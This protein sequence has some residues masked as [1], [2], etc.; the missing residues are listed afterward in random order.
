MATVSTSKLLS[1]TTYATA[2]TITINN[3]AV[4]TV[5]ATNATRPGNITCLTSGKLSVVNSSP[6][7]PLIF[8]IHDMTHDFRFEGNGI[9]EVRGA[10]MLLDYGT[11]TQQSWNFSTLYGGVIPEIT[12]CEIEE[13]PGSGLY[14]PWSIIR[15]DTTLYD[16]SVLLNRNFGGATPAAFCGNGYDVSKVLFWTDST[17]ILRTGD[18]TNGHTIPS[19]CAIR[20]PNIYI[21]NRLLATETYIWS[22]LTVGTPTGGTFNITIDGKGTSGNI[23]HNATAATIDTALE[24]IAGMGAGTITSSGGPLPTAVVI[25]YAG[26]MANNR[27]AMRVSTSALTGGTNSFAYAIENAT[28]NMT[29]IDLNP[30]GTLD[31]EWCSFSSKIRFVVDVFKAVRLISCGFCNDFQLNNTNGSVEIDGLCVDKNPIAAQG[32]TQ[33]ASVLGPVSIKRFTHSAKLPTATLNLNVLPGFTSADRVYHNAYGARTATSNR[34]LQILTLPA[35]SEITRISSFGAPFTF[36]NLVNSIIAGVKYTDGPGTTQISTNAM[37]AIN[38]SNCAS[39]TFANLTDGGVMAARNYTV[40][41]DAASLNVNFYNV[42][43]NY[44]NNTLGFISQQAGGVNAFNV[45]IE[46]VRTGPMLDLPTTYLGNKLVVKKMLNS[47]ATAQSTSGLD[48]GQDNIYD[49]VASSVVGLTES[50][51]GINNYVGG[52]FIDPG[53]LSGVGT[54]HLTIGPIAA[55]DSLELTGAAYTNQ[56]G[57]L[58]LPYVGDSAVITFPFPIHAITSFQDVLP[59]LWMDMPDVKCNIYILIAPGSPTGGTYTLS[60][61]DTDDVL[62][63]TTSAL[64]YN[65][66]T[67]AIDTALEA[68]SGIGS[69]NITVSGTN[70]AGGFTITFGGSIAASRFSIRVDGT[71]LTG[72]TEPGKCYARGQAR[73]VADQKIGPTG[74]LAEFS[75]RVPGYVW[76]AYQPLVKENLIAVFNDYYNNLT[77]GYNSFTTGFEFRVRFTAGIEDPYAFITQISIP[78]TLD[79]TSWI[80][81][82]ATINIR[83]TNPT[84]ITT[85]YTLAGT[86]V[87]TFTGSGVKDFNVGSYF[88]ELCYFT[89][90]NASSVFLASTYSTPFKLKFGSNGNADLFVGPQV[91]LAESSTVSS[92]KTSLDTNIPLLAKET[93]SLTIS[94]KVDQAK[95]AAALAAALSA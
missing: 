12:Y 74:L 21:T 48:A 40:A 52:N 63:G 58:F 10:P 18:G 51:T 15:E 25:S 85:L 32:A 14:M 92:I 55:G 53:T 13:S 57:S 42:N 67:T 41:T 11:D 76:P 4:L 6:D 27:N 33:I 17:K 84:D 39:V 54:G 9:F 88:N 2:E 83:G 66:S 61:Y 19:G 94:S 65:A 72:G 62:L 44:R 22:V 71:N 95:Q 43:L 5:D 87:A 29:I 38:L 1:E 46:N 28:T 60:V 56:L 50:F 80:V 45:T 89:R 90:Q 86:P 64:A 35:G 36:T 70:L 59:L 91:Q 93:T 3:G 81:G 79:P 68:I 82:D 16:T 7:T 69:G 23:A 75:M 31:A 26:A 24:A 30:S 47:F 20:I 49:V 78:T 77:N 34:G 8:S 73:L 37:S